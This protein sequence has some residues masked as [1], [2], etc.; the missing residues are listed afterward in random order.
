M[1]NQVNLDE[2]PPLTNLR[3]RYFARLGFRQQGNRVNLQ[4]GRRLLQGEGAHDS[5]LPSV[6]PAL[7]TSN[8][9]ALREYPR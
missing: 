6:T 3:T 1:L 9:P 5:P 8:S 7:R 2:D 4:K